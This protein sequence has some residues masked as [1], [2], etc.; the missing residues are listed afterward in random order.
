MNNILLLSLALGFALSYALPT[1]VK[2]G[3]KYKKPTEADFQE[4]LR[5]RG[6]R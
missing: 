5:R 6:L 3:V 1:G 4:L 2:P